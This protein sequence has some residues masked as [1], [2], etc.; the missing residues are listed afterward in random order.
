M[1][2]KTISVPGIEDQ[3]Q[4]NPDHL[5]VTEND[6]INT[7][8][9]ARAAYLILDRIR[10]AHHDPDTCASNLSIHRIPEERELALTITDLIP[11]LKVYGLEI[12]KETM[13]KI[14]EAGCITGLYDERHRKNDKGEVI[15]VAYLL[16]QFN[17]QKYA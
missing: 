2:E 13:Q 6:N 11:Y 9:I 16:A 17:I 1:Q 12:S 3:A 15:E 14:F 10:Y 8:E 5:T 7:K 4:P